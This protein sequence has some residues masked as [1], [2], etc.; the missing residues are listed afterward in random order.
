M[1]PPQIR[2]IRAPFYHTSSLKDEA[3]NATFVD[4]VYIQIVVYDECYYWIYVTDCESDN[5]I[6]ALAF[7]I[8]ISHFPTSTSLLCNSLDED[9][10]ASM[11]ADSVEDSFCVSLSTHLARRVRK[12][13]NKEVAVL[14][15]VSIGS[16][17]RLLYL[18]TEAGG[19]FASSMEFGAFVFKECY[20]LISEPTYG[21]VQGK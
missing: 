12:Q 7:A 14:S 2:A 11:C 17:K 8:G 21:L 4:F 3:H 6:G 16:E 1:A 18:G 9:G 13:L 10:G 20:R 19:G 5:K 15:N